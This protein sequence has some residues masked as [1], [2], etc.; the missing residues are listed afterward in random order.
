MN[1]IDQLRTIP[2]QAQENTEEK[3]LTPLELLLELLA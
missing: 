3:P 1:R 2:T